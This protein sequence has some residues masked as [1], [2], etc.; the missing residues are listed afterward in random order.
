MEAKHQK[1]FELA[2]KKL[3]IERSV[4]NRIIESGDIREWSIEACLHAMQNHDSQVIQEA[5]SADEQTI[6]AQSHVSNTLGQSMLNK[7]I[8][9][10]AAHSGPK[11]NN[12]EETKSAGYNSEEEELK[13]MSNS[14]IW[15]QNIYT[16]S[17]QNST[18]NS[19]SNNKTA[20]EQSK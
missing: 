15:T 19:K 4:F 12:I 13:Q 3:G 7:S 17:N 6:L 11:P 5:L 20:D 2:K 8:S 16:N 14:T 9:V 10:G 1:L 18:P